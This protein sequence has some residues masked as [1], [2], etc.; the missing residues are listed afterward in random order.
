MPCVDPVIKGVGV[1]GDECIKGI[2]T[3]LCDLHYIQ[4]KFKN[5]IMINFKRDGGKS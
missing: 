3:S 5:K 4:I 2:N 1:N